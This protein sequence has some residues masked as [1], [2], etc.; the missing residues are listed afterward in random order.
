[1][2]YRDFDDIFVKQAIFKRNLS[3]AWPVYTINALVIQMLK[4]TKMAYQ[5]GYLKCDVLDGKTMDINF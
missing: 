2:I 1:M 4:T 3:F 5:E